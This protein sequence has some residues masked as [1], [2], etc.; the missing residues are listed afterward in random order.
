MTPSSMS[1]SEARDVHEVVEQAFA[2]GG[3]G[4]EQAALAAG[5][6][7]HAHGGRQ[8]LAERPGGGLNAGGMARV[9]VAGGQGTPLAQ[10][11]Q[12]FKLQ[13][14]AVEVQLHVQGQARV[15]AREHEA[16]A[17]FPMRLAGVVPHDLLEQGVRYRGEAHGG[18]GVAVAAFCT[19]SAASS[20]AVSTAFWSSS[21][22]S[23]CAT[24]LLL[25]TRR[26]WAI[27]V[28]LLTL[29]TQAELY[30]QSLGGRNFTGCEPAHQQVSHSKPPGRAPC[31]RPRSPPH[32]PYG[33]R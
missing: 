33:E 14:V 18:A 2:D 15:A 24:A 21:V 7:R 22:H 3:L 9:G 26:I 1:P 12:T 17:A 11:L 8:A 16:V 28:C 5:G 19:A 13:T 23:N 31:P 32:C 20:R 30:A 6:H 29:P 4:V 27:D 10:A 25:D